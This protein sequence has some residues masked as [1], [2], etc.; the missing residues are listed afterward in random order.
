MSAPSGAAAKRGSSGCARR[1]WRPSEPAMARTKDTL[2]G[3]RIRGRRP[4]FAMRLDPRGCA[5]IRSGPRPFRPRRQP[6]WPKPRRYFGSVRAPEHSI[7]SYFPMARPG[8]EPG[9]PRFSGTGRGRAECVA[10][11]GGAVDRWR[12]D[13]CGFL[14]IR[15]GLGHQRDLR[16]L[17][18]A[19]RR[20]ARGGPRA[21]LPSDVGWSCCFVSCR[22]RM[23]TDPPPPVEN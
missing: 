11:Q 10:L 20:P 6:S 2:I 5:R 9:T 1:S 4:R 19:S 23:K 8:L 13:T 17:N 14:R 18:A 16:G 12:P 22:R 3:D 21:G 7:C 15:A